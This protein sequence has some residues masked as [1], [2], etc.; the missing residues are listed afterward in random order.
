MIVHNALRRGLNYE[1]EGWRLMNLYMSDLEKVF[2]NL[3]L[4]SIQ[5]ITAVKVMFSM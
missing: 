4:F 1:T 2:L 5:T 3:F